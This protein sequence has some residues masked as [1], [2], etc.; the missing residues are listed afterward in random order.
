MITPKE[1]PK[2]TNPDEVIKFCSDNGIKMVDLKF[3][4]LPGTLQHVSI[5]VEELK[6]D[7]FVEGTGFDG[8]SHSRLPDH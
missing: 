6:P 1:F 7:V 2:F 8:S 5:P 3:T 4:D